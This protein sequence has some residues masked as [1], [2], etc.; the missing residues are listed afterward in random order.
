M[1]YSLFA[2][3]SDTNT[4]L[5][6]LD[7]TFSNN[8]VSTTTYHNDKEGRIICRCGTLNVNDLQG[9]LASACYSVENRL[10]KVNAIARSYDADGNTTKDGI[11]TYTYDDTNRLA[12]VTR[13]G[14]T[15]SYSYNGLGQRVEKTVNG[16]STVFVYDEAGHLLGEYS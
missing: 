2:N 1:C 7:W 16:T 9:A 11:Y 8:T 6:G 4:E 15:V 3:I 10:T 13:T 5:I 12:G 14:L